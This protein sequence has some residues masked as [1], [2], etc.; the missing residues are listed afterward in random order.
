MS[1]TMWSSGKISQTSKGFWYETFQFRHLCVNFGFFS[2]RE[3]PSRIYTFVYQV[4]EVL[5]KI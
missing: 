1:F 3:D 5:C 4:V 2:D